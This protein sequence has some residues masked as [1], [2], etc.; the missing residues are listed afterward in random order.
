[1]K[2]TRVYLLHI[3]DAI[4][5]IESYTEG[6]REEFFNK[7]MIQDAVIRNLEII[8][9]ATKKLTPDLRDRY[10]EVPWSRIAGMRDVLIH[11]YF[12]VDLQIVWDVVQNRLAVLKEHIEALITEID[13]QNSSP[14]RVTP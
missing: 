9:E 3:R 14:H 1:M 2:D 5:Q 11:D 13:Q 8:G 10:P 6:G 7:K 4:V 12:E